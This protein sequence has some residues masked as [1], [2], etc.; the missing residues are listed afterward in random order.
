MMTS[1]PYQLESFCLVID[2][3][4]WEYLPGILVINIS[5]LHKYLQFLDTLLLTTFRPLWDLV[6]KKNF[7]NLKVCTKLMKFD[8]ILML[9]V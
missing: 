6:K 4:S 9:L 8:D 5:K 1:S 3:Q 2:S 7:T